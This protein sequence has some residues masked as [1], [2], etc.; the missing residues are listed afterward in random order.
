MKRN[1]FLTM[2]VLFCFASLATAA[3]HKK[4]SVP[5]SPQSQ[6]QSEIS[7]NYTPVAMD[8]NAS[9]KTECA[10]NM[11]PESNANYMQ[12]DPEGDSAASQNQVE[13]GGAG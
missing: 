5:Q 3:N 1:A 4:G 7:G 6:Q 12:H 8:G 11:E 13:Y 10:P 9:A 2:A